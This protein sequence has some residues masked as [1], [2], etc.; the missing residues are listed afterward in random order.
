M[1]NVSPTISS[2][3]TKFFVSPEKIIKRS[4]VPFLHS[5]KFVYTSQ[6]RKKWENPVF[7]LTSAKNKNKI[8]HEKVSEIFLR[9]INVRVS[10]KITRVNLTK[11]TLIS[12]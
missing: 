3:D 7:E 11:F 1:Y 2:R 6:N 9:T 12:S 5:Y 8:T 4:H 10:Q